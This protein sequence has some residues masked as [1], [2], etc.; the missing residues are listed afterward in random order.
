M[1]WDASWEKVFQARPWGKYPP[2]ELIR[3]VATRFGRV[4]D[5]K[6]VKILEIGCGPGAN[7]WFLAREGFTLYGIDGS[8]TAINQARA[9]LDAECPGWSG[10]VIVG[11][12]T[13]L[14]FA[15]GEIDAVLDV[16]VTCHNSFDATQKIFREVHR[17]LKPGGQVFSKCFSLGSWGDRTGVA[18][19]HNA[20]VTSEGP[21]LNVG[22]SRFTGSEEIT[23]LF[24]P[25]HVDEIN[26]HSRTTGGHKSGHN[27]LEWVIAASK[28]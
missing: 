22:F 4:P 25:L 13:E 20:W 19:G 15:D 11:D 9:R 1:S 16:A 7:L 26:L 18:A 5:R 6:Q 28:K 10:K 12:V 8:E 2:E 23:Q 27:I 24:G 17:V 21:L 3:F 14:P